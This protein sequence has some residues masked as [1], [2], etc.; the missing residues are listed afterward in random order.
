MADFSFF[1]V[2]IKKITFFTSFIHKYTHVVDGVFVADDKIQCTAPAVNSTG[3]YFIEIS[4]DGENFSSNQVVFEYIG[5]FSIDYFYYL[6]FIT[7]YLL[8]ISYY[9]FFNTYF[10]IL[11][12]YYFFI[13]FFIFLFLFFNLSFYILF[14]FI[15]F[16]FFYLFIIFLRWRSNPCKQFPF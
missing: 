15:L 3:S 1:S 6:F 5:M 8:L 16:L 7:Y 12:F 14:Y 11:I 2:A 4:E 9:L 13:T 10:L